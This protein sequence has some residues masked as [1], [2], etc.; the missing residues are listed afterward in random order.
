MY[1]NHILHTKS[2]WGWGEGLASQ[3]HGPWFSPSVEK[4]SYLSTREERRQILWT[5]LSYE[6]WRTFIGQLVED[7][8][9]L[10]SNAGKKTVWRQVVGDIH[11]WSTWQVSRYFLASQT[12]HLSRQLRLYTSS[13]YFIKN[14]RIH[15]EANRRICKWCL[16]STISFYLT[17][18]L[19]ITL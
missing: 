10:K 15:P 12:L 4:W 8:D 7:S 18:L 17:F 19:L 16:F 14:I 5:L 13:Y 9:L 6:G 2:I 11:Q 1:I 3:P